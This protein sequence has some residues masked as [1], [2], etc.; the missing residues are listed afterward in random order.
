VRTAP[1][2]VAASLLPGCFLYEEE[3]QPRKPASCHQGS[4]LISSSVS[5]GGEALALAQEAEV[6]LELDLEID[7]CGALVRISLWSPES[8]GTCR[9]QLNVMG[10]FEGN[11]DDAWQAE[12]VD[13]LPRYVQVSTNPFDCPEWSHLSIGRFDSESGPLPGTATLRPVEGGSDECEQF[14][15]ELDFDPVEL[16]ND[17]DPEAGLGEFHETLNFDGATLTLL[18]EFDRVALQGCEEYPT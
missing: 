18:L 9:L 12:S 11:L 7:Q 3:G 10:E 1:L 4:T 6:D 8:P 15:L 17:I 14:E 13:L 2:V 16:D 5:V